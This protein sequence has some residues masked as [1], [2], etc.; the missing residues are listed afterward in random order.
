MLAL[1][2]LGFAYT[3]PCW[4]WPAPA[5]GWYGALMVADAVIR[6]V[7]PR[8]HVVIGWQLVRV[9]PEG[10][11]GGFGCLADHVD[12]LTPDDDARRFDIRGAPPHSII[13]AGASA[14]LVMGF[15][16]C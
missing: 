12:D 3:P 14:I 1:G 15:R 9:H 6:V 5:G 7:A 13:A 10:G 11:C 4:A 8:P 16:S 2:W